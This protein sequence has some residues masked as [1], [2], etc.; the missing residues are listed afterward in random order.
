MRQMQAASAA[1]HRQP[2]GHSVAGSCP[3]V[4]PDRTP[5]LSFPGFSSRSLPVA[6][7]GGDAAGDVLGVCS[8]TERWWHRQGLSWDLAS[9]CQVVRVPQMS[10]EDGGGASHPTARGAAASQGSV[11]AVTKQHPQYSH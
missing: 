4:T 5:C 1:Q 2:L 8:V 10:P 11:G 7:L 9:V 3:A 6:L